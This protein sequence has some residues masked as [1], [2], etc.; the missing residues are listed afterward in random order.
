[1]VGALEER[2]ALDKAVSAWRKVITG[3]RQSIRQPQR[4]SASPTQEVKRN[5]Q[6]PPRSQ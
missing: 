2:Q 3:A 5:G 1:M 6:A 4:N